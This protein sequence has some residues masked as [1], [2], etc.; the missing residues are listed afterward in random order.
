MSITCVIAKHT[1]T[2]SESEGQCLYTVRVESKIGIYECS[3]D[4]QPVGECGIDVIGRYFDYLISNKSVSQFVRITE[5]MG[6]MLVR[7]PIPFSINSICLELKK[8]SIDDIYELRKR[9]EQLV[10]QNSELKREL[11]RTN[12]KVIQMNNKLKQETARIDEL[13]RPD[14]TKEMRVSAGQDGCHVLTGDKDL[15][16]AVIEQMRKEDFVRNML[17]NCTDHLVYQMKNKTDEEFIVSIMPY[18]S[19]KHGILFEIFSKINYE[20]VDIRMYKNCI[21]LYTFRKSAG[22]VGR[23]TDF[24]PI[25]RPGAICGWLLEN[26][27]GANNIGT[28][29]LVY[30]KPE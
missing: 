25:H 24:G 15:V 3:T 10:A 5:E 14:E 2:V 28:A 30:T 13:A 26:N 6:T 21:G 4:F 7:L 22:P 12:N 23:I 27:G 9:V 1:L 20:P 8:V 29:L 19:N 16:A 18:M 17:P 11:M